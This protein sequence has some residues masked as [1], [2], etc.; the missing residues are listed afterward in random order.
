VLRTNVIIFMWRSRAILAVA[1]AAACI[2]GVGAPVRPA[3]AGEGMEILCSQAGYGC[4][5]GTGYRGQSVWGANYFVTGHN[6][7]SY[8]SFMLSQAGAS[9]PWRPMGNANQ[10][11]DN[12][13]GRTT[14][15]DVPAIGAVAQWEGG[16]RLAPGPAGHVAMV[17][18]V[19]PDYIELSD[20]N[21][22]GTARRFRIYVGSPYW[23]DDF[24]HIRDRIA[25]PALAATVWD[26]G[27]SPLGPGGP[28]SGLRRL[29]AQG[30]GAAEPVWAW[31][32]GPSGLLGKR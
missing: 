16:T 12:G 22:S 14:I 19:T 28:A 10:W 21:N 1:A 24:L 20:D 31:L 3:A 9:Q 4:L 25:V 30:T 7:T 13:A 15:D 23:P 11:D 29:W 18:L 5:E 26:V 27:V 17:D 32:P 8:V 2:I 6:C